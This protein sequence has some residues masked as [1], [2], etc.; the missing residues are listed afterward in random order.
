MCALWG[1]GEMRCSGWTWWSCRLRPLHLL[2][3]ATLLLL[4][5]DVCR[6]VVSE[7]MSPQSAFM[8][9][10]TWKTFSYFQKSKHDTHLTFIFYMLRLPVKGTIT[11]GVSKPLSPAF[12]H[13][14]STRHWDYQASTW[15]LWSCRNSRIKGFQLLHK[16]RGLKDI[17]E[18]VELILV[19]WCQK[20]LKS[21][22]IVF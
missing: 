10:Y 18:K 9:G 22:E 16:S 19:F 12:P 21:I 17:Q 8:R 13:L 14:G 5:S 7:Q 20:S 6:I 3:S 1:S 4:Q 15:R 2:W 11:Q